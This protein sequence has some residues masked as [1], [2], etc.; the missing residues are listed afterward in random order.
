[1]AY[2]VHIQARHRYSI[3]NSYLVGSRRRLLITKKSKMKMCSRLLVVVSSCVLSQ[4]RALKVMPG[5]MNSIANTPSSNSNEFELKFCA[6]I[7]LHAFIHQVTHA[8][9]IRIQ[10]NANVKIHGKNKVKHTVYELSPGWFWHRSHPIWYL[11]AVLLDACHPL[12]VWER[13]RLRHGYQKVTR[14]MCK[15]NQSP[16]LAHSDDICSARRLSRRDVSYALLPSKLED[17]TQK[18]KETDACSGFV[19]RLSLQ[20]PERVAH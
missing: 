12:I 16:V 18:K 4:L 10:I 9:F 2:I 7:D 15:A 11:L 3:G 20:H 5:S 19:F 13:R 14:R 1:M 6:C 8:I 17:W